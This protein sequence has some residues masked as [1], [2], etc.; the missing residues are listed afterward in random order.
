MDIRQALTDLNVTEEEINKITAQDK[1]F[2]KANRA[3]SALIGAALKN[4]DGSMVR[5]LSRLIKLCRRRQF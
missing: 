2:E 4:Y 1:V 5:N 3:L